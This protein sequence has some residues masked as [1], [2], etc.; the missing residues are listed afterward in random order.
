MNFCD[1][2]IPNDPGFTLELNQRMNY[3]Q[4][5]IENILLSYAVVHLYLLK[6]GD[7]MSPPSSNFWKKY[8]S[9]LRK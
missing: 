6:D 3:E 9:S 4:V 1:K 7:N 2:N 8:F 5:F